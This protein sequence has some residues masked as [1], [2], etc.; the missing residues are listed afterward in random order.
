MLEV[1]HESL[2]AELERFVNEQVAPLAPPADDAA[3]RE[4]A[5]AVLER[6]GKG[7]WAAYAVPAAA[8]GAERGAGLRACCL[9]RE[10]LAFASP[11]ADAVF[12]LQALGSGPLAAAGSATLKAEWLPRIA[13]GEVM[14]A[15]AMSEREAGSDVGAIATR[16]ERDG[17]RWRLDGGKWFISNAGIADLYTVFASTDP[18]AGT[19]G[20]SCFLVPA[21]TPG[22]R[23]VAPQVLSAPHP[24]GE[25]E[26]LDCR[27]PADHLLGD[28]HGGF[29]LGMQTLDRLRATVAAAACGL[30]SR[31]L[32]EARAHAALRRQFGRALDEFQLVQASLA[33]MATE[34]AAA[35]LLTYR[36]AWEVDRGGSEVTYRSAMAKL[37]ATEA[38]QRVVDRAVQILGGQGV[39]AEHPVDHLYR[40]VRALRIYEGASD[41]Q[42][43]I[44]AR[45]LPG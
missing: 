17:D 2:A 26:L 6:L 5:R 32:V 44:I 24:L 28:E 25:I 45:R 29:K 15:F 13:R 1:E 10:A 27:V 37:D 3:G 43:L 19:R 34:L 41:I 14:T 12:A 8:G 31:A 23:F 18:S 36:A 42:R 38:A 22:L 33:E 11:L 30:A 40:A 4:Q 20:L 16:A 7:G 39:L 9:I 35:R 21:A